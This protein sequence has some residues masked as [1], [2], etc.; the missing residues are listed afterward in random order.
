MTLHPQ[1]EAIRAEFASAQDRL[2][3]LAQ[4]I[5]GAVWNRR[6]DP[7]QWSIAECVEHLNLTAQ[8]YLPL[9]RDALD[10]A[11]RLSGSA[12][13][14]YRRD[15]IGWMLWRTQGPPVR[16]R[17]KTIPRFNPGSQR[18]PTE[19]MAEF[20]RLQDAQISCVRAADGLR[21]GQVWIRS[22]FDSR[23]RYNAYS[24]LTILPRHQHRHLW[25][26]EQVWTTISA[27]SHPATIN[28]TF[29]D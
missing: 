8:A 10:R 15:P 5:P 2:S 13:R 25:Q 14:R 27:A 11:R 20:V 18:P 19:L 21:L 7:A 3:R 24:C 29:Q 1:L 16:R 28:G 12:P 6:P 26:A 9:L 17:M 22:P 4:S 23:I